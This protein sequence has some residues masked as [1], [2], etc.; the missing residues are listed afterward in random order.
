MAD[1]QAQVFQINLTG[2]VVNI[3][4]FDPINGDQLDFGDISVHGL[5]LG[6]LED[7]TAIITSPWSTSNYIVLEG[8]RWADLSEANFV[9]VGNEHL[10]QDIGG[11][12]SWEQGLGSRDPG[13]IYVRSHQYG[14]QERVEN[15]DP[16]TQKLNFLYLGTRERLSVQDTNE[17]LLIN[18]EPSGQSLLLVGVQRTD[19]VAGNLEF[20]H[21]QVMEDNLEEPFGFSQDVVSLVS[22][23]ELFTPPAPEG[24]STDGLQVRAGDAVQAAEQVVITEVDHSSHGHD[25]AMADHNAMAAMT[26]PAEGLM[27]SVS[28]SLYWGGM[29]GRLTIANAGVDAV[30]NWSVSFLTNHQNFQ[31]WAGDVDVVELQSGLYEVT[32]TPASWN[33][34]IAAGG[35][36]NIDFNAT[37]VGLANAGELTSELFFAA[38][39][40]AAMPDADSVPVDEPL[41]VVEP[42]APGDSIEPIEAPLDPGPVETV[43]EVTSP[44]VSSTPM[45]PDQ[46]VALQVSLGDSWSGTYSGTLELTNTS[47]V[48]WPAG[49]S[50][51]FISA[52]AF[53]QTSN[54]T[55]EQE[56]M[57]D[58]RYAVTVSAASWAADQPLAAGASVSSYF[59]VSGD[60]AGRST[61]ELFSSSSLSS[62]EL[63]ETPAP[64]PTPEPVDEPIAESVPEPAPETSPEPIADVI[65]EPVPQPVPEAPVEAPL[66]QMPTIEPDQPATNDD[67]RVV[68]YFEEWGIYSRDFTVADVVAADLTHLNYSF[69]DVKANG[70]V[71]LFDAYAAT[72][73]R[74][75]SDEQVSRSFSAAEWAGL[76][77]SS[78]EAYGGSSDFTVSTAADGAVT[79]Q[80][81]PMDWNTPGALA[82]NLRQL[83]LLKELNPELNLGMALGGWT[84]SDEFSLA[85]D[86]A[87]GREAFT[88]NVINTLEQYSFITTVDFDWEY[89]GGG[90][91]AGNAVSVE[92]GANFEAT[93]Q[94]LRQK[95]DGL[96]Q[97]NGQN[98]EI[99]I[100][101]AGG[102]DKLAN[103]NLEGI[104]PYVDFY[105]VMTYDFHGGWESSTGHQAA[106]TGDA[107]GYDVLTAIDQ[108]DQAGIDRSKVVLGAPAYTRA[109][110]DVASG[111][112]YGYG[113]SGA[114][115]SAS[116]SFEAGNYD[117]KDILTGV[118]DG[119][120]T[121]LWDDDAKAAYAYNADALIWSSMET[122]ATIAGKASYV[123]DAGLGGM[124]F[125]A[126]SND[127]SGDQSLIGAAN[128]VLMGQATAQ[129]VADRAPGF[130]Q[131][132]GGDGVFEVKDFT[133]LV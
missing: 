101:T 13:T 4:D 50:A 67:L 49:W 54:L 38:D 26:Q 14:V 21:D 97:S 100:A 7:G 58:G 11:V 99:S 91:A 119:S 37:S 120:Y 20:H 133:S 129:Q 125:W 85:L 22:R 40:N 77:A 18:T 73:K 65:P 117:Y 113:E 89:P 59:Q 33:N 15:F 102:A 57:A 6:Q 28:G 92:D 19:L 25:H 64:V 74:F 69:F 118:Q 96:E 43:E 98:Y 107:G 62:S 116:G 60:L 53:K 48:D 32:L 105:N 132:L 9:P 46:E 66:E 29:G 86:D 127:A 121:L 17:G 78:R 88:S 34:S 47:S 44:P 36:L 55:L 104:D 31:S 42:V 103:L 106:M 27:L 56:L 16:L 30:E 51:S 41:A 122:T 79:V 93:L 63:V 3:D 76:E 39:P 72:E 114:A 111:D 68:G 110:G 70:D 123:Q 112:R 87:A 94:L 81:V 5:I 75:S 1:N 24:A 52:D 130:D 71:T 95:L 90:G 83:E 82:G 8:V 45:K 131:V 109:W 80:A 35:S 2:E 10:R 126:L 115:S 23:Q 124:M 61:E 84:L 128:D 12:L 108:F